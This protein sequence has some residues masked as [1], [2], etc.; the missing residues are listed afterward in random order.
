MHWARPEC[1]ST[2]VL[3]HA[4]ADLAQQGVD[5]KVRALKG[6]GIKTLSSLLQYAMGLRDHSNENT[7]KHAQYLFLANAVT[8]ILSNAK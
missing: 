3:C 8:G 7:R 4:C 2:L 6:M 1:R 5:I